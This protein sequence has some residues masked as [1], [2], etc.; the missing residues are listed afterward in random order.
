MKY[1]MLI[2]FSLTL[3]GLYAQG[4]VSDKK[5]QAK[6][7]IFHD[8]YAD[9]LAVLTASRQAIRDDKEAQLCWL[10]VISS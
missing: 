10:S 8:R 1:W 3:Q 9:A 6:E 2:V 5:K 7:Y 4:S